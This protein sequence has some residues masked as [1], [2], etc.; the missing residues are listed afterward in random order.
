M[1]KRTTYNNNDMKRTIYIS[2]PISGREAE[3]QQEAAAAKEWLEKLN[4][5]CN[6]INP[7]D[8]ADAVNHCLIPGKGNVSDRELYAWY[9]SYDLFVIMRGVDAIYFP[10]GTKASKGARIEYAVAKE[11]DIPC[12]GDKWRLPHNSDVSWINTGAKIDYKV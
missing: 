8:L 12:F 11:L 3:A 9:L 4:P 6:V 2:L 7:F 5:D 1:K 10:H